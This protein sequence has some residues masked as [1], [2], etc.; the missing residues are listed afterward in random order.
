[1]IQNT[2]MTLMNAQ[3]V[4]QGKWTRVNSKKPEERSV[5]DYVLVSPSLSTSI[6]SM[7]ID[8]DE[9]HKL[10]SQKTKTDHNTII[11]EMNINLEKINAPEARGKWKI[12]PS[13]DWT[14]FENTAA[15]SQ[16]ITLP[17]RPSETTTHY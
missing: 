13:T 10:V 4:C 12:N 1:M 11:F 8:E 16:V 7:V 5:L 15:R 2:N 3:P 14:Q 17:P 9:S 6:T